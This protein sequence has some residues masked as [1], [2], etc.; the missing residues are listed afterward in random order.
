MPDGYVNLDDIENVT[1]A[2]E[3]K[4][5]GRRQ[6]GE[7][8]FVYV[9]LSEAVSV[10][11]ALLDLGGVPC[12]RDQLAAKMGHS[13]SGA[14]VN[15]MS[16]ARQFGLTE[17]SQGK[18]KLTQLGHAILDADRSAA[19]K[20]AAFLGVE[21]HRRIY[22]T[23]RNTLLPPS[24]AGLEQAIAEFGVPGKQKDKARRAF[25]SSAEQAGFFAHGRD[26]LVAPVISKAWNEHPKK[27][28]SEETQVHNAPPKPEDD[29]VVLPAPADHPFVKGLLLSLPTKLQSNWTANDRVKWLR[30]AADAFDLMFCGG[31]PITIMPIDDKS[32]DTD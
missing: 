3:K 20:A 2:S 6:R 9:P 27:P 29:R 12:D 26:R 5:K 25:E 22:E 11:R 15:K 16:A 24:P 31:S 19:A 23:F 28:E 30:T 8:G 17:L 7:I 32:T 21:L 10:A 18:I 4:E 13:L 1:N 14:F